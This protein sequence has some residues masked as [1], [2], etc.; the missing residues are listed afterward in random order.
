MLA[1]ARGAVASLLHP[2][3]RGQPA[4]PASASSS[5]PPQRSALEDAAREL[6]DAL[7]LIS[8]AAETLTETRPDDPQIRACADALLD[9]VA[10]GTAAAERLCSPGGPRQALPVAPSSQ[11]AP[12]SPRSRARILVVDDTDSVRRGVAALLRHDGFDVLEAANAERA[13]QIAKT[14]VDAVVTDVVL[15]DGMDGA[16]LSSAMRSCDPG[17]PVIFM[18]GYTTERHAALVAGD[19]AARFVRK[20]V[21]GRELAMLL[22]GLLAARAAAPG[23]AS[24]AVFRP[25]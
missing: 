10:R 5:R 9:A 11:P 2:R 16:E 25:G 23:R 8:A 20:P 21:R 14:G 24:P 17:L 6:G 22:E 13:L 4:L 12:A 19:P 3:T 18:S 1:R 7:T 15:P